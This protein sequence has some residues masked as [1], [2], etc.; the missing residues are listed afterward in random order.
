LHSRAS[1]RRRFTR[2]GEGCQ[3]E[4][5]SHRVE[6]DDARTGGGIGAK[7]I[8]PIDR[9]HDRSRSPVLARRNNVSAASHLRAQLG[10][11]LLEQIPRGETSTAVAS[12]S[13]R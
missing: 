5:R 2:Y 3:V 1:E 13:N 10:D 4:D 8:E 11:H 12:G 9:F 6:D 7:S